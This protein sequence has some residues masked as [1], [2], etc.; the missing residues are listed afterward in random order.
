MDLSIIIVNYKTKTAT[1]DCVDSCL[2]EGSKADIEI[3][4]VD[5]GSGDG[6]YEYFKK[7]YQKHKNIILIEN[8][9]NLGFTKAVN[10]GLKISKGKYK[11]LLNSD[12]AITNGTFDKLIMFAD[13]DGKIGVIGTKLVL[14]DGSIQKSCF[15]FPTIGNAIREYWFGEREKYSSFYKKNTSEVDSVVG[16]S[17]FITPKAYEQVGIFDER[18]FMFYEDHDYCRRVKDLGMKVIYFPEVTVF[19][20]HGLSGKDISSGQNQWRRL[21]PSSKV[22]NGV[23]KHYLINFILWSGQKFFVKKSPE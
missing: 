12:T 19:H 15:N 20:H 22:F 18:Y 21:I 7:K 5:N 10:Q 16:A 8:D 13:S 3:I 1:S 2:G 17:F 4:V 23:L 9:Q 11:Y 6:S 14:P